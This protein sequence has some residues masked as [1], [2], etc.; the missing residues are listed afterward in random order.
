MRQETPGSTI[1]R[2]RPLWSSIPAPNRRW[3]VVNALGVTAVINVVVNL[4]IAW[5]GTRGARAVPLWS[6]PLVRPSTITDTVGTTFMLPFVTAL[7]CGAAVTRE[8]RLGRVLPL[9]HQC[10]VWDLFNR[11]PRNAASRALLLALVTLV[12]VGP[13]TLFTLVL[14]RFGT[15]SVASF[16]M[17]KV[18][19]AVSLGL[20]VTP[21]IAL[22]AMSREEPNLRRRAA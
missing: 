7:T 2:R 10:R 3:I 17:F 20:V 4:A 6:T 12:T 21:V 19:Y 18:A 9:P 22:A 15:V 13:L 11:L 1:S 8:M 16:L 14:I 5:L